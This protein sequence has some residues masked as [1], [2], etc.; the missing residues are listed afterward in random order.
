M[1]YLFHHLTIGNNEAIIR[2][3]LSGNILPLWFWN[4]MTSNMN[5]IAIS[6]CQASFQIWIQFGGQTV[7]H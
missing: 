5:A 1:N 3:I 6:K 2:E 4:C 7:I